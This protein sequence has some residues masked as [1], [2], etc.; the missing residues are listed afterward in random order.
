VGFWVVP[1]GPRVSK[2]SNIFFAHTENKECSPAKNYKAKTH[3]H[4][5]NT[6]AYNSITYAPRWTLKLDWTKDEEML[7]GEQACAGKNG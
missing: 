6:L 3:T 5:N 7:F 2:K 4:F 1:S